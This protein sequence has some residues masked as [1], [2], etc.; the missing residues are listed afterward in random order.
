[1]PSLAKLQRSIGHEVPD[2]MTFTI[3]PL[4]LRLKRHGGRG[5]GKILK[6]RSPGM[7]L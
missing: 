1:M 2:P 7:L 5:G 3:Q 4:H 6:A